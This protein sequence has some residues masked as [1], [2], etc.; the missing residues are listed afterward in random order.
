MADIIHLTLIYIPIGSENLTD[1]SD[2]ITDK[3]SSN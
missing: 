1:Y 3:A 2:R